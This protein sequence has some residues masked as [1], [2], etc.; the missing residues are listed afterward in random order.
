M[1]PAVAFDGGDIVLTYL[2]SVTES[3]TPLS[4]QA[5]QWISRVL[6]DSKWWRCRTCRTFAF[7]LP[8]D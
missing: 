7:R 1:S 6:N 5:A 2:P 4:I 8:R 3:K